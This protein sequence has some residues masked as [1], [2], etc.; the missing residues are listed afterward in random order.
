[1]VQ[2]H[3]QVQVQLE[4]KVNNRETEKRSKKGTDRPMGS[5]TQYLGA[6]EPRLAIGDLPLDLGNFDDFRKH[7]LQ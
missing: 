5:K 6:G 4:K 1:M 3:V 7:I 2:L